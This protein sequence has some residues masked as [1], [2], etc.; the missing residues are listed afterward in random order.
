MSAK[1]TTRLERRARL[2]S[3]D[4]SD[5]DRAVLLVEIATDPDEPPLT[6]EEA[7]DVAGR[8]LRH[9]V[10]A[11]QIRLAIAECE[12]MAENLASMVSD[13]VESAQAANPTEYR[14]L[15]RLNALA[16]ALRRLGR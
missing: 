3:D 13:L 8:V 14:H 7:T 5:L 12:P 6:A 11:E 9:A 10:A 4:I 2:C 15:E 16:I 1:E